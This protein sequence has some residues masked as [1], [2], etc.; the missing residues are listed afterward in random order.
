MKFETEFH[1]D[2]NDNDDDSY[3]LVTCASASHFAFG[4]LYL[5]LSLKTFLQT[6]RVTSISF[7]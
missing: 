3:D 1:I 5:G 2:D 4:S 7:I 6:L